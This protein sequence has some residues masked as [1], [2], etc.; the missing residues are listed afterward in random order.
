MMESELIQSFYQR[1]KPLGKFYDTKA[2][3]DPPQLPKTAPKI[4]LKHGVKPVNDDSA[5]STLQ[6]KWETTFNIGERIAKLVKRV[7][8]SNTITED[9]VKTV[10]QVILNRENL[11]IGF[12]EWM[13]N[14]LCC[15]CASR[16]DKLFK[17]GR[18][19]ISIDL[20]LRTYIKAIRH[21]Q[22][23]Q[24][25][26]LNERQRT[27]LNFQKSKVL[28]SGS[29][30]ESD[31]FHTEPAIKLR[32]LDGPAYLKK[33]HTDAINDMLANYTQDK[34]L[35]FTDQALLFGIT[36]RIRY[37]DDNVVDS[38]GD[39]TGNIEMSEITKKV[40]SGV[41]QKYLDQTGRGTLSKQ[42]DADITQAESI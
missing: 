3:P 41:K 30:S 15:C 23:M 1:E 12:T 28:E 9:E 33:H 11:Q 8:T 16:N 42:N 36:S 18:K 20:D 2:R 29:S 26:L 21:V 38:V 14:I 10:Q 27:L 4:K 22:I 34:Q 35:S 32:E 37:T 25:V 17:K 24:N 13:R 6:K 5:A 31:D 19:K 39:K 40:A 7:T